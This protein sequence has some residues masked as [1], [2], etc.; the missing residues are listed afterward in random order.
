MKCAII[1]ASSISSDMT[2]KQI[3]QLEFL[4]KWLAEHKVELLTGACDGV[5]YIVGKACVQEGGIVKGFSPAVD[6]NDHIKQYKHPV[7]GCTSL[8]FLESDNTNINTRFLIR[9]IPLIAEADVILCISG[10][11]GTLN[12]VTVGIISGKKH[13]VLTEFG[14]ISEMLVEL[15]ESIRRECNY[16]Y[17]EVVCFAENVESVCLELLRIMNIE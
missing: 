1:G 17:G 6:L 2:S 13:I 7:D 8:V 11:W 3:E 16:N 9:S 14:G 10:N 12:E 15:Y 5:P 4:G